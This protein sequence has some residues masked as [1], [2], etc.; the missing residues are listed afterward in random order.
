MTPR[1]LCLSIVTYYG[2]LEKYRQCYLDYTM[3][4]KNTFL[5]MFVLCILF[6]AFFV[7]F[8]GIEGTPPGIYPDESVN[9]Q[10]ALKVLDGAPWQWFYPDNQG[11][12]GLF[13]NLVAVSFMLFG[14]SAMSLKLP[15]V[16][17]GTLTVL[18]TYFLAREL[19]HSERLALTASFFN[20]VAFTAVNFSRISFRANMLPFIL[21]WTF[22]FL[23][24]GL[25]SRKYQD[26]II[27]GSIFG[28]GMHT[29]IAF[30]I[31]PLIL[32]ALIPFLCLARQ[33]FV[34]E[35][36]RLI[37]AFL[38]AFLLFAA[39][40]LYTFWDHPEYFN[41]RSDHVSVFSPEVNHGR[42]L[43]TLAHS[44][45]LSVLKYNVIGDANWRNNYPPYPLLDPVMSILFVV[46]SGVVLFKIFRSVRRRFVLN[47]RS[48]DLLVYPFLFLWFVAMLAP[49][50]LTYESNPHALRSIG[51]LPMVYITAAL[52]LHMIFHICERRVKCNRRFVLWG[53]VG[54]VVFVGAFNIF[55]Y[56]V[57][58]AHH[59]QTAIYFEKDI[60]QMAYDIQK[61]PRE[62]EVIVILGNMQRVP[63]R[64][65]NWNRE[66]YMDINPFELDR[67]TL[68]DPAN[69]MFFFSNFYKNEIMTYLLERYPGLQYSEVVN[70]IG[71]KYYI[72]Q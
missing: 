25:H 1:T 14:V 31:A 7:R 8:Y 66:N 61:I 35:Y 12:E 62:R 30:R 44:F 28:L 17:F 57:F 70:D 11:R 72:L 39:P 68:H 21:V 67:I 51:T 20:A 60:T 53:V 33:N 69:A 5:S 23:Y 45:S 43:Q 46:G 38:A 24:K 34:K 59:P 3:N 36:W 27:A 4:K 40:M 56:F 49:E 58:W 42:P 6:V 64:M 47:E 41:S 16:I 63:V 65:F 52:G 18:G 2:I 55:K 37:G 22:Y 48:N 32:I 9:G 71:Q 29:Y 26:F 54:V 13:M 15:A 10:D 50:F 19:F